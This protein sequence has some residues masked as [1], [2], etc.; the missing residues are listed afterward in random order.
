MTS[1]LGALLADV[2]LSPEGADEE[3][4]AAAEQEMDCKLPAD[5]KEL[6]EH[7][8][9]VV[10]LSKGIQQRLQVC[11]ETLRTLAEHG[12]TAHVL[13]TEEAVR[14]YNEIAEQEPVGGLFH[15][16]C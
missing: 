3:R 14:R 16:T 11:P 8:A 4:I 15:S 5:V 9:R 10:V 12:V 7:G 6:L 13:Q 2:R 1:S